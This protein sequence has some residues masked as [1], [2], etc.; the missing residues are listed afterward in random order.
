MNLYMCAKY[1]KD[2]IKQE[3]NV[4]DII[5]IIQIRSEIE[6][7]QLEKAKAELE[8]ERNTESEIMR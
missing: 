4:D 1:A 5:R 8:I 2:D 7:L 6:R 3:D